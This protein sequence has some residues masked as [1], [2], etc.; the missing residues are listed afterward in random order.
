MKDLVSVLEKS[1]VSKNVVLVAPTLTLPPE[2]EKDITIVEFQLPSFAEIKETLKK[3]IEMN[4]GQNR[5]IVSLTEDEEE[6]LVK[7]ALGLTLKEAENAF[8]LALVSKGRLDSDSVDQILLKS[9]KSLKT[10]VLEFIKSEPN[11]QDVGGLENIKR[12]L[13]KRNKSWMDSAQDY[14]LPSPKGLLL[15]GVPGCGKSLIAKAVSSMWKLPLLK[16]DMGKIFS[17]IVGSSEENMRNALSTAEAI[18]PSIL[19]VDE[20]EKDWGIAEQLETGTSKRVLG[21]FLTWMQEKS[22]P[23][24]VIAT[25]NNIDA[26]PPEFLRK[27]RFDEIFL[28]ICQRKRKKRNLSHPS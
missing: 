9:S 22:K 7:A 15:T 16:L 12:W 26:L 3:M 17:G 24:F 2:L 5:A 19:W 1:L 23:V 27:G 25:A 10:G 18:S 20:I 6:R 4:Q 28:L 21:N 13:N 14:G 11:I 8:A